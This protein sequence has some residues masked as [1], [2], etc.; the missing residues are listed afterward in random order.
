MIFGPGDHRRELSCSADAS[1]SLKKAKNTFPADQTGFQWSK[2]WR[3]QPVAVVFQCFRSKICY[4]KHWKTTATGWWRQALLHWNPVWSA[5]KVFF[6]FF[7]W[8][9]SIS[10]ATQFS[11]VVSRP[12]KHP[13]HIQQLPGATSQ[14]RCFPK[15]GPDRCGMSLKG[16][17]GG[18]WRR[19]PRGVA[20]GVVGEGFVGSGPSCTT[21]ETSNLGPQN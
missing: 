10:T 12:K 4:L 14:W 7:Q 6:R 17:L 15:S 18:E 2:A 8:I 5:G 16:A 3:H 1:D 21:F 11:S 19:V 13:K 9:W 20:A